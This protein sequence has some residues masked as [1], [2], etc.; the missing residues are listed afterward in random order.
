M[1]QIPV[2]EIHRYLQVLTVGW[3]SGLRSRL[4]NQRSRVRIPVVGRGFCVE[5]LHLLTGHGC[6][7]IYYYQYKVYMYDLS[8][9]IRYLVSITQVLKDT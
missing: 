2:M 6:L 8:M 7:Y 9:F 1:E 5:Q 4:Q 3:S